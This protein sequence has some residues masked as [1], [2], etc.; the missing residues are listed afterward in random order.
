MDNLTK[1]EKA[2]IGFNTI[3]AF[4]DSLGPTDVYKQIL[5]EEVMKL[6]IEE[7]KPSDKFPTQ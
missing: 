7:T 4:F 1:E 3:K 2:I 6:L 5:L